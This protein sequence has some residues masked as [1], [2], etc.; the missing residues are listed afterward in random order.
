[1]DL[2]SFDQLEKRIEE[3]TERFVA[4][5]E[6]HQRTLQELSLKEK[7]IEELNGKISEFDRTKAQV[8]SRIESILKRLELLQSQSG[9]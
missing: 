2:Q 3:L 1:M 6:E 7:Q 8:H 9:L 5:R 4:L